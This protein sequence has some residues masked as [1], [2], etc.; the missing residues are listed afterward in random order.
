LDA[1]ESKIEEQ[2]ETLDEHESELEEQKN[3]NLKKMNYLKKTEQ[4]R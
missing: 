3:K 1:D 2:D 4:T